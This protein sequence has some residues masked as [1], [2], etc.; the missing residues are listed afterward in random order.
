MVEIL[1]MYQ[2]PVIRKQQL[3][4]ENFEL[5]EAEPK[6]SCASTTLN[7]SVANPSS[8]INL[9]MISCSK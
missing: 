8:A 1:V 7:K 3:E 4:K 5:Q 2:G 6:A 9:T